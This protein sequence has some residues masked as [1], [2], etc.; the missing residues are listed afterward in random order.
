MSGNRNQNSHD[1]MAI[2]F[3]EDA[4]LE[5]NVIRIHE[6]QLKEGENIIAVA[7]HQ[8]DNTS[9]GLVFGA[10]V[11]AVTRNSTLPLNIIELGIAQNSEAYVIIENTSG[12]NEQL[13][14]YTII[15]ANNPNQTTRTVASFP[16]VV[17]KPR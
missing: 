11:W 15:A 7:V 10:E 6:T 14:D 9:S 2:E 4:V 17:L 12:I 5:E 3:F 16:S 13:A 8:A 1:A